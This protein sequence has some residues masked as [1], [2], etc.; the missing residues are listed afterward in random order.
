VAGLAASDRMAVSV[1]GHGHRVDWLDAPV[2]GRRH[3]V[4]SPRGVL[5]VT[6]IGSSAA[7]PCS[8][9]RASS[10][11]NAAGS[12]SIRCRASNWAMS[13]DQGESW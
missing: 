1:A 5:T 11:L 12:S 6:G 13:V 2:G 10:V 8:A 4:S 7:S 9:S 3:A